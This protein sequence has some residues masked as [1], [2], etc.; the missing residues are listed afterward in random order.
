[1]SDWYEK[2]KAIILDYSDGKTLELT[3]FNLKEIASRI[4][5][6]VMET[7]EPDYLTGLNDLTKK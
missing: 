7:E 4:E 3:E 2:I 5:V 1:M 6:E